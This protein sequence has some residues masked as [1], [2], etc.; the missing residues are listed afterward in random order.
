MYALHYIHSTHD[1][2]ITFSSDNVAPMHSYVHYP[3]STGVEAYNNAVPPKLENS[4]MISVYSD[5]CW[6][7]QLGSSIADGT[8][9]SLFK[10]W[11]MNGGI[12]F[13][14]GGPIGWL[15]KHQ[16]CTSLSSCEAKICATNATSKK[17]I[18]FRNLSC[19]VLDSG[20]F[21]PHINSPSTLYNNNNACVKW[22]HNSTSKA[23]RHIKH[24]RNL[25]RKWVQDKTLQVCHVSGKVNP[26][27]IFTKE[28]RNGA[29]FRHLQDSF[30][31]R[32]LDFVDDSILAIH[33]A[34]QCSPKLSLQQLLLHAAPRAVYQAITPPFLLLLSSAVLQINHICAVH[35]ATSFDVLIRL[36]HLTSFDILC[37]LFF[38][39]NACILLSLLPMGFCPTKSTHFF[40]LLDTRMGGVGL[41]LVR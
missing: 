13:K 1:Y 21:L 5:L 29:H 4:N 36:H 40:L 9:L 39:C 22:L 3:P 19:S 7:S 2:S 12:V 8:L 33:H 10:F 23:A 6:G 30:T 24:C 31:T 20:H 17:V 26:A 32:L 14:N 27:D 18:D 38:A 34:L 41:S 15:G 37:S 28:M 16:E 11:S 35:V 25:V